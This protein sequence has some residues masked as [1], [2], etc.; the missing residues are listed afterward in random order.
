MASTSTVAVSS[1][2]CWLTEKRLLDTFC[3]GDTKIMLLS[4][5]TMLHLEQELDR[6]EQETELSVHFPKCIGHRRS[7]LRSQERNTNK[8]KAL[9]LTPPGY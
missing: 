9:S 8:M 7:G 3:D 1:F 5:K 2:P 4:H 6:L